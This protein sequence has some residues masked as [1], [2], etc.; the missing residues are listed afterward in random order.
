VRRILS[1][2][3]WVNQP[4]TSM[5]LGQI[6]RADIPAVEV[7]CASVHFDYRSGEVVRD[8]ASHFQSMD[9]S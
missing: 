9:F 4:L 3:R 7:F 1:T 2:Y 8:L 5:L 6:S